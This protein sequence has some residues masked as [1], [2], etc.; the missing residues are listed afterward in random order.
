[1]EIENSFLS[2]ITPYHNFDTHIPSIL[3]EENAW[4]S[5]LPNPVRNEAAI[6][7]LSPVQS[8][9]EV[10]SPP[11]DRIRHFHGDSLHIYHLASVI[12]PPVISLCH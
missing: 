3:G 6:Q 11:Q 2:I 1:M 9:V 10:L 8:Y 12:A 4:Q 7:N 5:L